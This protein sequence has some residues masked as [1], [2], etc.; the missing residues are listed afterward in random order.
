M[1]LVPLVVLGIAAAPRIL[2]AQTSSDAEW[3]KFVGSRVRVTALGLSTDRR[4]GTLVSGNNDSVTLLPGHAE[5]PT[6][7]RT[8]SITRLEIF[9]G[10]STHK[11]KGLLIG[12]ATGAVVAG[13][14]TAATWHPTG[15][16]DFGRWGDAGL[17][18]VPGG[19]AGGLI[20]LLIGAV[21]LERWIDVPIPDR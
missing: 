14:V 1:R 6:S 7:V 9:R 5:L 12:F 17:I 8:S 19:L 13:A 4:T 15:D 20:G 18:A 16:F 10:S 2:A 3:T 21:P 11:L